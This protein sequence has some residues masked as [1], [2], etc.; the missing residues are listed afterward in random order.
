MYWEGRF[1]HAEPSSALVFNCTRDMLCAEAVRQ[2]HTHLRNIE[3][4]EKFWKC[5][6]YKNTKQVIEELIWWPKA[7][8]IIRNITQDEIT[9]WATYWEV[10]KIGKK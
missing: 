9:S 7:Q 4:V 10:K 3:D 2:H 5:W 1:G 6:E 8:E